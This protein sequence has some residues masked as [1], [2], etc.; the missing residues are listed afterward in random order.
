M[1][2]LIFGVDGA[3]GPG[4]VFWSGIGSDIP[5]FAGLGAFLLHKNC[6]IHGC[7]R[8]GR[9]VTGTCRVHAL[10]GASIPALGN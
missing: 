5:M 1:L 9:H 4:Y 2:R 3:S 6:H 8:L 7:W 10:A